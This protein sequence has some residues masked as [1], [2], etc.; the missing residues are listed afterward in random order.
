[1]IIKILAE[2][3][4]QKIAEHTTRC[5]HYTKDLAQEIYLELYLKPSKVIELHREGTLKNYVYRLA[6]IS[7]NKYNGNFYKKYRRQLEHQPEEGRDLELF[8]ILDEAEL[9]E[10]ESMWVDEYLKHDCMSS[11]MMKSTDISRQHIAKRI[12]E[13]VEKC[14]KSL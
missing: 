9:T 11:W 2:L 10:I 5:N 7:Y 1:M 12:K 13:I 3:D 6:Y 4:I 8:D 14:K